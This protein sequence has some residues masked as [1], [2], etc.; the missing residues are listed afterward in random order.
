MNWMTSSWL[1]DVGQAVLSETVCLLIDTDNTR[2]D[3]AS[4]VVF[5][6]LWIDLESHGSSMKW[7][8][9]TE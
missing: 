3:P 9:L 2:F 5:A 6:M 4:C 8:Y 1:R 7:L